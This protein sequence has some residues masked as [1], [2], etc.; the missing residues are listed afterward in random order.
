MSVPLYE[1]SEQRGFPLGHDYDDGFLGVFQREAVTRLSTP[2]ALRDAA[3]WWDS[4]DFATL[5][6][7]SSA[8]S[9]WNDKSG[10][11]RNL[12]QGSGTLRPAYGSRFLNGIVVPDFDGTD[13]RMDASGLSTA[14][15]TFS[16]CAVCETDTP[17]AQKSIANT[18][19][20]GNVG[21]YFS[22][23]DAL[24][25]GLLTG[26]D[27]STQV[28]GRVPVPIGSPTHFFACVASDG[29]TVTFRM[30]DSIQ[31]G[32]GWSGSPTTSSFRLGAR[33]NAGDP[34]NGVIAEF[35]AWTRKITTDEIEELFRYFARKWGVPGYTTDIEP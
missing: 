15:S 3:A 23:D 20:S 1:P 28:T 4:A 19:T 7:V 11:G 30:N 26:V 25:N 27:A 5:T 6:I 24:D 18:A 31:T 8:I 21:V 12:T 2:A 14:S 34:W 13:D 22:C 29:S 9:Q 33:P 17:G 35:A 16:Y 10:N 32:R